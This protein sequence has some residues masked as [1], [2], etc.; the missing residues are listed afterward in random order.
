MC[1]TE[2]NDEYKSSIAGYQE[3]I[4]GVSDNNNLNHAK[5]THLLA[6]R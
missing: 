4:R 5:C 3:E 6:T 1:Q 2:T